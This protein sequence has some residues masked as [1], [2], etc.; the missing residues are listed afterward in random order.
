MALSGLYWPRASENPLVQVQQ[1]A[2]AQGR[3]VLAASLRRLWCSSRSQA[4]ALEYRGCECRNSGAGS[5]KQQ[6]QALPPAA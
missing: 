1:K 4:R 2:H 5:L 6:N 3:H